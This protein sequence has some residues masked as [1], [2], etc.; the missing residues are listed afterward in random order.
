MRQWK[1]WAVFIGT[2]VC[3]VLGSVYLYTLFR[4]GL[5]MQETFLYRQ[6]DGSFTGADGETDYKMQIR[7]QDGDF[8]SG[9]TPEARAQTRAEMIGATPE[10]LRELAGVIEGAL[11]KEAVCVFGN[12]AI[13]EGAKAD[14]DVIDLFNG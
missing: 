9:R 12:K 1:K 3:L 8:L 7:R 11:D 14:L 13:L 2:A 10:K 6:K 4:P 5:W